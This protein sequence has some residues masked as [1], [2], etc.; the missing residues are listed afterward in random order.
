MTCRN[1]TCEGCAKARAILDA[2]PKL[3]DY[4]NTH[5][6][7]YRGP[8]DALGHTPPKPYGGHPYFGQR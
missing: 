1:C 6:P 7:K 2:L 5:R 3:P 4:A 8:R